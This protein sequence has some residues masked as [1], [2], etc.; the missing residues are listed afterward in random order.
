MPLFE[1]S[2]VRRAL[3]LAAALLALPLGVVRA[4]MPPW[5]ARAV[6]PG[7]GATGMAALQEAA[8]PPW[9][10][11]AVLPPWQAPSPRWCPAPDLW[12]MLKGIVRGAGGSPAG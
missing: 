11:K 12:G 8:M 9:M 4:A 10:A 2:L 1:A 3:V 6:L 5:M 7:S